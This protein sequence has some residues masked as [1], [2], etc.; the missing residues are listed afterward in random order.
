MSAIGDYVHLT[1]SG[2][3]K[4]QG[5]KAEPY[6]EGWSSALEHRQTQFKN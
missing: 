4:G 5:H 6:F 2:Y 3:V 1:Y